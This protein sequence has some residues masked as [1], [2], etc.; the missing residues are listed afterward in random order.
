M[1]A[2]KAYILIFNV[3]VGNLP[4]IEVSGYMKSV[5]ESFGDKEQ[6]EDLLNAQ[7]MMFFVP[8]HGNTTIEI[9][10]F[11]IGSDKPHIRTGYAIEDTVNISSVGEKIIE[12]LKDVK[13]ND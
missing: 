5:R 1:S 9:V 11:F 7:V 2:T 13:E 8:V 4:P 10:E 3:D 12:F 6:Y